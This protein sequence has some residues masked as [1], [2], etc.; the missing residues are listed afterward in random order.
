[1]IYSP[2]ST[3]KR[4]NVELFA[5]LKHIL[6]NISAHPQHKL[7]E[8]LTQNRLSPAVWSCAKA[9]KMTRLAFVSLT[10]ISNEQ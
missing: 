4:H 2:V 8:L 6:A 3:A 7:A 1:M 10:S 5:Y 9:R